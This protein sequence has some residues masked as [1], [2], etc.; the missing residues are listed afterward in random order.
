MRDKVTVELDGYLR[1]R[2]EALYN[3]DLDRGLLPSGNP[4]FPVPLGNPKGQW[5]THADMRLRTDLNIY[6]PGAAV[7]VKARIDTLDNVGLGS[8][9]E[10]IPYASLT[11][12][13]TGNVL[14]VRRAYGEVLLPFGLLAVGRMGSHWG[15]G[16]LT[17]GGDCI[18]CDTG[19]SAD[20]IAFITP[21]VGHVFAAA[22]D[23]SA[24]LAQQSRASNRTIGLAPQTDVRSFTFAFLRFKDDAGRERRRKAGKTTLDYGAYYAH[25]WQSDD[26]PAAYLPTDAPVALTG[27][28]VMGR[29]YEGNVLDAW[30]RVTHP[31]L[32]LEAEIAYTIQKIDQPSL[33][34]GFLLR[35]PIRSNQLGI[36]FESEVGSPDGPVGAGVDA[37]YASGDEG[38]MLGATKL[39]PPNGR[40]DTFRFHGDYRVDRILFRE[41]LGAVTNAIYVRPHARLRLF[42]L[43]TGEA[44]VQVA[45]VSSWTAAAN[46]TPSGD[47]GLGLEID[48]SLVFQSKDGF[49]TALDYAALIPFSGLDNPAEGLKAQSAQSIRARI[50]FLF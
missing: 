26:I 4:L 45:A 39:P 33:I 32:R 27:S 22:F 31:Y 25:R 38:S 30:V 46:S 15:L 9:P 37:G 44:S 42:R 11:Q 47:R 49:Y 1:A 7:A 28:Q 35:D 10:G 50:A 19:D 21:L 14:R 8:Q 40:L 29:G 48:P 16:M 43:P 36:A 3:L 18:D 41:I 2:S 13:P 12:R 23:F 24:T 6:A 34:P 20:R 17:N 5:L